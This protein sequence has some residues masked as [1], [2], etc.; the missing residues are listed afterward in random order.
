MSAGAASYIQNSCC[1]VISD[2]FFNKITLSNGPLNKTFVIVFLS[3]VYKQ[4]LIPLF[5][6]VLSSC[7]EILLNAT[8]PKLLALLGHLDE[9]PQALLELLGSVAGRVY[10]RNADPYVWLR[11]PLKVFPGFLV[12]LDSIEDVLRYLKLLS[13]EIP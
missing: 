12:C 7:S 13:H 10:K 11:V 3:V 5:H 8:K 9:A 1:F 4:L 6:I 2:F